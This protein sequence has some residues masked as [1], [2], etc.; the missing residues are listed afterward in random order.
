MNMPIDPVTQTQAINHILN[1]LA[2]EKGGWAIT[3]NLDHLR[4]YHQ[5]SDLVPLY[6][7]AD[8]VLADGMPL[9]WAANL[10]GTP[11]PQRVPGSELIYTLTAAAA[12]AHRSIFLLGGNAG[13][14]EGAARE[15]KRLDPA[16]TIAGTHCP[17]FGFEKDP[18]QLQLIIDTLTATSPDIVFV[19]LGFPKQE[20]LIQTL[21]PH[22][23][24]AW[25]LGVG[26]SFS[27]VSGEI[28][29]A[30]RWLQRLGLEWIHRMAQEPGRLFR[31]YIL[32]D[33][34]FAVRLF[35]TVATGQTS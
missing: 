35:T 16:L 13:A 10:Q 8:L 1:S 21:R 23:P 12:R 28:H 3:P 32:H 22:F 17:P 24:R 26:I 9:L 5:N 31:R 14:A 30:P 4:L 27:F 29:R 6:E 20:K 15:L 25:F 7:D 2:H 33:L 34:P 19:G 11:L 18:D